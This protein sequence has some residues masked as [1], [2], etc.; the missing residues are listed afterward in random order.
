[1]RLF[2]SAQRLKGVK[3]SAEASVARTCLAEAGM[4]FCLAPLYHPA[5]R[6]VGEV[7]R[8]PYHLTLPA[9]MMDNVRRGGEW[10]G[11]QGQAAPEFLFGTLYR[12][13]KWIGDHFEEVDVPQG[14]MDASQD[15]SGLL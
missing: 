15:P 4:A 13:R 14:F 5:L 9:W 10:V 3:V 2:T 8:N 6:H 7:R 12:L 11:G 1:M